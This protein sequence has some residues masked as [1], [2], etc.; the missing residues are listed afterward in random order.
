MDA[1]GFR[2]DISG[3]KKEL[4]G[5]TEWVN[6]NKEALKGL[7]YSAGAAFAAMTLELKKAAGAS[8]ELKNSMMGLESVARGVGEDV[9]RAKRAA[10]ELAA[11]GLMS[12][13][14]AATGLK[15][16]LAA[17]FSLDQA[18]TLM[19]RF[20]DSAAFGR[21]ASLSFGDAVRSA[22]EG[23]KNGNSILVSVCPLAA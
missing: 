10:Q 4:G 11:D 21:Q 19:E 8:V 16:L 14:D 12:V 15:N 6:K 20:K 13:A 1:A 22:T 18:I 3:V 7:A 17:G 23:I 2:S 5:L 9:D